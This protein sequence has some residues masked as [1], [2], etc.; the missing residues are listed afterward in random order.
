MRELHFFL[1]AT[2]C[3]LGVI[4]CTLL[5]LLLL[6]GAG[7]T[8][9]WWETYYAVCDLEMGQW[10]E[11]FLKGR[12]GVGDERGE[13]EIIEGKDQDRVDVGVEAG[14]G[15]GEDRNGLGNGNEFTARW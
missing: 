4:V 8:G 7:A 10:R 12:D 15:G 14:G 2:R 3:R 6:I 11:S 13:T 1:L 9:E 5:L